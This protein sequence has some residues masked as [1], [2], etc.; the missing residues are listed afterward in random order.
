MHPVFRARNA[1]VPVAALLAL[2][3]AAGPLAPRP[4]DQLKS[5]VMRPVP[6]VPLRPAPRADEVWVPDRWV[7]MPGAPQGAHVPGH[8]ERR[9]SDTEYYVPPLTVCAPSTGIC[10]ESPAGV[11][12]PVETRTGP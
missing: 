2:L 10:Q 11:R 9:L 1:G 3:Q 4:L 8:R 12:G 5:S 7:P 6:S